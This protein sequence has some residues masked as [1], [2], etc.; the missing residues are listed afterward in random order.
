MIR[1]PPRST[2]FPYT[3][4]FRSVETEQ[5]LERPAARRPVERG[6]VGDLGLAKDV[7][8]VR[9]EAL[10]VAREYEAGARR[11]RRRDHPVQPHLPGE[12]LELQ[13]L[14]FALQQV[15]DPGGTHR[16]SRRGR[17]AAAARRRRGSALSSWRR[18]F[19]AARSSAV[20]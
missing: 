9:R 14:A 11:F 20:R 15:A 16:L 1:R 19:A 18:T 5:G 10:G 8:A 4:L 17:R 3:T 7:D 13:E 6:Q 12:R 2:L